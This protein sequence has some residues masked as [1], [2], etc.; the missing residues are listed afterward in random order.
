MKVG[1]LGLQGGFRAH[2]EAL[3]ALD[4]DPV[5]VRAPEHLAGID[6]IVL[7]GG[8]STAI[9]RLLRSS[10]LGEPLADLVGDGF[11]VLATCAGLILC[12]SVEERLTGVP[13]RRPVERGVEPGDHRPE[14]HRG[15]APVVGGLDVSLRRNGYG[16]Q[17]QSFEADLALEGFGG[18]AFRGVFIRA[19]VITAVGEA[20]EV[21]ARFE[22]RPVLCRQGAVLGAC[23][24]PELAGDLRIHQRFLELAT[25]S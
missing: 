2:H 22:D 13:A 3:G 15:D 23:F 4:A 16:S 7:P 17:L 1:V 5:D 8:E 6:A 10:G 24:H 18:G 20:V 21:L 25:G 11:P 9:T 14:D 19:P 12:A